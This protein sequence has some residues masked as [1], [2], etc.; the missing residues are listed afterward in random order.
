VSGSHLALGAGPEFDAIRGFLERLGPRATGAGDDAAAIAVPAGHLLVASVDATIEDVHF[1][2]AW[3]SPA[4]L[5][6]R[7]VTAALSDLAA[8]AA[9]PLGV[10]VAIG[11]PVAWRTELNALADGIGEAVTSAGTVVLGGNLS[12]ARELSITTTV[13]GHAARTLGRDRARAGHAV[14]VTGRLGGAG[15][16]LAALLADTTPDPAHRARFARPV[17]RIAE[18]HWLME[19]GAAAAVDISDGLAPDAGHIAAASGVRMEID[20]DLLPLARGVSAADAA[21]SGE[22]YELL[23]TAPAPLDVEAFA[24][25]FTTPLTRIGRVLAGAP[26]EVVVLERGRRVAVAHRSDHFSR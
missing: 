15:A 6:Y 18:A 1:R 22:E 2:C 12:S 17:A 3:L 19:A 23:V 11:L 4:E 9:E 21:A 26:P 16:A 8:M 24:A 13:I 14:Y 5:G 25:R 7:A 10:L 20:L